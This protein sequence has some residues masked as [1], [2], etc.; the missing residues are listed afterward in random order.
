MPDE[1]IPGAKAAKMLGVTRQTVTRWIRLGILKGYI[2]ERTT[3]V[4]LSCVMEKLHGKTAIDGES[5]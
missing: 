3:R 4:W 5:L 2:E 1:L